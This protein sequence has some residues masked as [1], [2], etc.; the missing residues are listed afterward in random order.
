DHFV[1]ALM[2]VSI[3]VCK[4]APDPSGLRATLTYASGPPGKG[5]ALLRVA[6]PLREAGPWTAR[7]GDPRDLHGA[8]DHVGG[9]LAQARAGFSDVG[10]EA[11]WTVGECRQ[12]DLPD[13]PPAHVLVTVT[14]IRTYPFLLPV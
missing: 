6:G 12:A 3:D 9:T 5:T 7:L 4:G 14:S 1:Q 2:N 10:L 8:L 11:R 13:H